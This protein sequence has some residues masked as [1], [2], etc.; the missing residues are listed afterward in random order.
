[1][2]APVTKIGHDGDA[3]TSETLRKRVLGQTNGAPTS[4]TLARLANEQR[5]L[6]D[7]RPGA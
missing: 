1:M 2:L 6:H 4:E 3:P 5:L 7:P